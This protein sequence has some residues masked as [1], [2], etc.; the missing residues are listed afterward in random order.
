MAPWN[1]LVAGATWRGTVWQRHRDWLTYH[2]GKLR[3]H[4]LFSLPG[5]AS[6][7]IKRKQKMKQKI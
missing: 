1:D 3:L 2:G 4:P 7:K 5:M 6:K